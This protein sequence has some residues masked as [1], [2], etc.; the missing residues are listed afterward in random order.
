M[1]KK[2][3]TIPIDRNKVYAHR[4]NCPFIIPQRLIDI[5]RQ[6]ASRYDEISGIELIFEG[7]LMK[8]KPGLKTM[9]MSRWC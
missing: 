4:S 9:Y 7:E 1:W 6:L 5:P 3:G 2:A 8:Y